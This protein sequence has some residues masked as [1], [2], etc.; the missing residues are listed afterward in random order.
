MTDPTLKRASVQI[1]YT[2]S[3]GYRAAFDSKAGTGEVSLSTGLPVPPHQ[4][5]LSGIE[6]LA[7][8]LSLFGFEAEA[9]K[10]VEDAF[11]RVTAWRA[12]RVA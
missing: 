10:E 9:R 5:L 4:A 8:A 2:S 12:K 11:A 1:K 7:R 3:D 6:E